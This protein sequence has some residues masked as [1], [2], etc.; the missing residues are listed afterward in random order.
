VGVVRGHQL[1]AEAAH[2]TQ[3]SAKPTRTISQVT[4]GFNKHFLQ[5]ISDIR[6][7]GL[8]KL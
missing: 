4:C 1:P 6:L 7:L 8:N 2:P 5:V 3:G